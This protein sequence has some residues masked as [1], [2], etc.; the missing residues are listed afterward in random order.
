MF[1]HKCGIHQNEFMDKG[2]KQK[3]EFGIRR[4]EKK[5]VGKV[6]IVKPVNQQSP[7]DPDEAAHNGS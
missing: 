7:T 4:A 6:R 2:K 3:S 5:E 1:I